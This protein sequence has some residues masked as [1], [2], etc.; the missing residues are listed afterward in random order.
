MEKEAEPWNKGE[1]IISPRLIKHMNTYSA[2][3]PQTSVS[4]YSER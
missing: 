4:P 1:D 2:Q 3:Y